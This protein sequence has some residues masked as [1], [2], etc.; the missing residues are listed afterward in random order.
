LARLPHPGRAFSFATNY[1]PEDRKRTQPVTRVLSV[2]PRLGSRMIA[3]SPKSRLPGADLQPG[4]RGRFLARWRAAAPASGPLW[5]RISHDRVLVALLALLA[6]GLLVRIYFLL[7]WS[8]AITGYSDSGIYFDGAVGPLSRLWNDPIRV[9]GYSM[10]LRLLHA[11]TPHLIAVTIVQHALGLGAALLFFLAVRRCGGPRG[12]GLAPAAMIALGGDELFIEHAALSDGVFVFLLAAMLYSA[13]RASQDRAAWAALAG[14]CAGLGVWDREAGLAMVPL[15]ALWLFFS[16]GRPTRRGLALGAVALVLSMATVGG[17]VGWR[18]AA[19]G[20]PGLLTSNSAWN[21]YGRVAPWADCTKFTPPP[22]TRAL[23][24]TTPVSRRRYPRP[25]SSKIRSSEYYIYD[26]ESPAYRLFGPAYFVSERPH[27]M[28]TLRKWSEAVML[29]QPLDYLHA[30]WLDTIRLFDPNHPSYGDLSADEMVAL[31]LGGVPLNSGRNA[32]VEFWQQ[33]LYPHDPGPHRGDIAPLKAWERITR[34]DG[35][36][37]G[38]LLALC[39]AGAWLLS[40]RARSGMLLFGCSA[41]ALLFFP[42]LVKGY[43]YRFVI[44]AFGPLAAG[45]ALA[46]WGLVARVKAKPVATRLLGRAGRTST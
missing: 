18:H 11:I 21:L 23:C 37:M 45:G 5:Q 13:L 25:A 32:F 39:L 17:Y 19:S 9:V 12:L 1:W 4:S 7:V 26:P 33:R 6:A 46:A 28:R 15:I 22:G 44:A 2:R 30:V 31:M 36:W 41:L 24:E 20:A 40:G 29:G 14:I 3:F 8:P 42:I 34:V 38:L 27:A 16:V 43:D 35:A 10:Y